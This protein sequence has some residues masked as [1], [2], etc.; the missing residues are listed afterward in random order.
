MRNFRIS[1]TALS[2]YSQTDEIPE[3]FIIGGYKMSIKAY[4]T[5]EAQA[6]WADEVIAQIARIQ[7]VK[8]SSPVTGPYDGIADVEV[9]DI[10][11]LGELVGEMNAID[12]IIKTMTCIR[13]NFPRSS[14]RGEKG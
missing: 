5:I 8:S 14:H 6:G 4:V 10:D 12:G 1:K 7:G 13:M 3:N 11:A 2:L 9:S